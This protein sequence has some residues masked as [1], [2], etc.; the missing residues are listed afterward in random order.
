MSRHLILAAALLAGISFYFVPRAPDAVWW[1]AW[2]AIG[3]AFLA[4]WAAVQA[5]DANGWLL[6]GVL[7]FGALGDVL[8]ETSGMAIGGVAFL[9]GHVI[10]IALYL[11][12]GRGSTGRSITAA[13]GGACLVSSLAFSFTRD[14]GVALYALG[15]GGMAGSA[16]ASRFTI[17]ALGAASFALSDLMIFAALG[18][19]ATSTLP[20]LVIWPT[21]FAGQ[22]LVA[23]GVMR[24]LQ[25]PAVGTMSLP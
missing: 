5:R 16:A 25:R 4:A 13:V 3:V 14:P 21:Y 15:L 12:N 2:K 6:V 10:A 19:L 17:A 24:G 9:V 1:I 18:P 20:G 11:G 7:A 23:I 22:V 8:L